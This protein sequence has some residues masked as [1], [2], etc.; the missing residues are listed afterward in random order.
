M[1]L[2]KLKNSRHKRR[3]AVLV[4][5][6]LI[7]PFLLYCIYGM[8]EYGRLIQTYQIVAN[9]AREGGRAASTGSR[10]ATNV[11]PQLPVN[12]DWEV[13]NSV[14]SY[15]KN[16][17]LPI[18][19]SS[20]S[21]LKIIV[22]NPDKTSSW[23]YDAINPGSG[24]GSGSGVDPVAGATQD[25]ANRRDRVFVEVEYKYQAV[26]WSPAQWF[27]GNAAIIKASSS[28]FVLKDKPVAIDSS[29]PSQPL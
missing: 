14:V 29:I 13:Q 24:T 6:A 10:T 28:W 8:W 7:L 15:M 9:A 17:G 4:E 12:P 2:A 5:A 23:T 18:N 25:I 19:T 21:N 16:A 27:V 11:H 3:G 20:T 26:K 1:R 22:S